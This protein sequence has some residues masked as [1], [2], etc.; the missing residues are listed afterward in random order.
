MFCDLQLYHGF[1][2]VAV[3]RGDSSNAGGGLLTANSGDIS[4]K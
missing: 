1:L 3:C 2:S 4:A